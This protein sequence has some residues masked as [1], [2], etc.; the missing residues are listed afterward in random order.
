VKLVLAKMDYTNLALNV[1]PENEQ[2][3]KF[4]RLI[5]TN[6]LTKLDYIWIQNIT[7]QPFPK[8]ER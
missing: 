7:I 6:R 1:F 5:A 4:L 3:G 8:K 2:A